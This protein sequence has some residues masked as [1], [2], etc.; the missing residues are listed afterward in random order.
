MEIKDYANYLIYENGNVFSKYKNG[1]LKPTN[2]NGYLRVTLYNN[3]KQETFGIHRLI[4]LHYIENP[5]NLPE[6]DHINQE[7]DDNRIEN[8]R[9]A[10]H[11][12]NQRNCKIRKD[13][14]SGF[15]GIYKHI[16]KKC[17][18]GYYYRFQVCI[19]GKLKTIK[20][21]TNEEWLKEFATKWKE[22][23]NYNF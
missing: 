18:Q 7:R 3:I 1:F 22:E 23:N 16:D 15:T 14:K 21:S 17:K 10:T 19:D 12:Q 4:A 9:W 11:S 5:D 13:N 6:V 20:S 8:L 2:Y